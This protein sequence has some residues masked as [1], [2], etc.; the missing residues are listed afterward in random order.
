M[1]MTELMAGRLLAATLSWMRLGCRVLPA[2][3]GARFT[4]PPMS[5]HGSL[6]A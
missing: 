6:R 5:P 1:F 4:R 3:A 2:G